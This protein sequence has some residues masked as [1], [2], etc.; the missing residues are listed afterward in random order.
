M[1]PVMIGRGLYG[2]AE[3]EQQLSLGF[4]VEQISQ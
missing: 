3:V 1:S 2:I 4:E